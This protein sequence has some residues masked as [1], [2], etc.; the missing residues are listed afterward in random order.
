MKRGISRSYQIQVIMCFGVLLILAGI[1]LTIINYNGN[2]G[3]A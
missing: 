2:E 1:I 3:G